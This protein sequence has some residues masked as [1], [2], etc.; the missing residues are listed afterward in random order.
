M[1]KHHLIFICFFLI[2][3]VFLHAQTAQ[4][5]E[6]LLDS[7]AVNMQEA[8]WLV[9]EAANISGIAGPAEAFQYAADQRWLTNVAAND[10]IRLDRLSFLIMQAFNIRG[11]IFYGII[12]GPH[13][14][15]RELVNR[16]II[17]GRIDPAMAVSGEDLLFIVNRVLAFQEANIL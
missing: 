16:G 10:S 6:D 12:G 14:A 5:I 11:G 7:P 2:T 1:R 4:A 13:Y 3:S 15:Y 9:L 17:M 8:A